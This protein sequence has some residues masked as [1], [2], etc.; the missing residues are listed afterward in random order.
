M[1]H[2]RR[3]HNFYKKSIGL[4]RI[5]DLTEKQKEQIK[6]DPDEFERLNFRPESLENFTILDGSGYNSFFFE[7]RILENIVFYCP[8]ELSIYADEKYIIGS[9]YVPF[10]FGKGPVTNIED[11]SKI[12]HYLFRTENGIKHRIELSRRVIIFTCCNTGY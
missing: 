9:T 11:I 12:S 7:C 10:Q 6:F 4:Q 1:T 2:Q 5:N 3:R 8:S